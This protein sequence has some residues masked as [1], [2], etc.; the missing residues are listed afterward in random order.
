MK[1]PGLLHHVFSVQGFFLLCRWMFRTDAQQLTG[2]VTGQP[3]TQP[4]ERLCNRMVTCACTNNG[5]LPGAHDNRKVARDHIW[6]LLQCLRLRLP[7][8][9]TVYILVSVRG[10][11]CHR[12][13][14]TNASRAR[15]YMYMEIYLARTTTAKSLATIYM[16]IVA[17]FTF[18]ITSLLYGIHTGF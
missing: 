6:K 15:P 17:M 4:D 8:F 12:T 5:N 14:K 10:D 9:C 18:T 3:D 11:S 13:H 2:Y 7:A 16:E 1:L